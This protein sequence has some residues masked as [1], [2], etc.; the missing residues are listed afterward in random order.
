M[1]TL[2]PISPYA[3]WMEAVAEYID[4]Y[5]GVSAVAY[6]TLTGEV[7]RAGEVGR[8]VH[9]Y[10]YARDVLDILAKPAI[11]EH[12]ADEARAED[13][14]G[15]A[16]LVTLTAENMV[17]QVLVEAVEW[18]PALVELTSPERLGVRA[19]A[20]HSTR[21]VAGA[22]LTS[23]ERLGVRATAVHSTR[24]VAGAELT[25]PSRQLLSM[26]LQV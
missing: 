4:P 22:E 3:R 12:M 7:I 25:S 10:A 24:E 6:N 20:V 1:G 5:H 8:S 18:M 17:V 11:R 16:K 2:A 23:P 19:T 14:F 26:T 15:L 13:F 21:E 9:S